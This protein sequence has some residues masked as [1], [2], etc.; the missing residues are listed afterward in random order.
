MN[1]HA[2][3]LSQL[4]VTLHPPLTCFALLPYFRSVVVRRLCLSFVRA[5]VFAQDFPQRVV[6]TLQARWMEMLEQSMGQRIDRLQAEK[7]QLHDKAEHLQR[8]VKTLEDTVES[9]RRN[10]AELR[11]QLTEQ[12]RKLGNVDRATNARISVVGRSITHVRKY[13][14]EEVS[15]LDRR[16]DSHR[17]WEEEEERIQMEEDE[18]GAWE[19]QQEDYDDYDDYYDDYYNQGHDYDSDDY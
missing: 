5:L 2:I 18:R 9:L 15:R 19:Q 8:K 6:N 7:R 14:R 12:Q 4:S 3:H 10:S 16:V 11:G 13:M 1:S 17:A